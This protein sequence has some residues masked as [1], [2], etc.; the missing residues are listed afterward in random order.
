[1]LPAKVAMATDMHSVQAA[2]THLDAMMMQVVADVAEARKDV[3]EA[4]ESLDAGGQYLQRD[5]GAN[6]AKFK[7]D[8]QTE[9]ERQ[10]KELNEL[11]SN[12]SMLFANNTQAIT[13]IADKTEASFVQNNVTLQDIQ[14]QCENASK[15]LKELEKHSKFGTIQSGRKTQMKTIQK[16]LNA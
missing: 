4:K 10:H 14:E 11:T 15:K 7:F 3:K 5:L 6:I 16:S 2:L 13:A 1:M 12:S 9:F 8:A